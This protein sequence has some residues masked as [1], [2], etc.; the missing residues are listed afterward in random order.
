MMNELQYAGEYNLL[1]CKLYTSKS[2]T[3]DLRQEIVEIVKEKA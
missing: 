3:V 1:E 2:T